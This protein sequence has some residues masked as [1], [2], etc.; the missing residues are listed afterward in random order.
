M[1]ITLQ[2]RPLLISG[3]YVDGIGNNRLY[4]NPL[5]YG[6]VTLVD[7]QTQDII[8]L[9][10]GKH[11]VSDIVQADARESDMVIEE[12]QTL[13]VCE[14][15][16][17]SEQF[18]HELREH[19]THQRSMAC[20]MHLTNRCNLACSYCY[21]HK[22]PGD[23]SLETGKSVID[24]MLE[25]CRKNDI[26]VLNIKFAGG[27][28]LLRFRMIQDLVD[29]AEHAKGTIQ[30][31]YVVLTNG[32]LVTPQKVEYFVNHSIGAG[33][34]L[35]G[36]GE[37]H[38]ANRSDN[39]GHGSF[40]G[41]VR[42]LQ[43]LKDA[44]IDPS[45]MVTVAP[46][47]MMHLEELTTFLMENEYYFRF[48]L[49]RDADT[50]APGLLSSIPQLIEAFHGVYDMIEADLPAKDITFIHKFG[51]TSFSRPVGRACG[52]GSNFFAAGHDGNLGV[53][54]LGLARPYGRLT[55]DGD[56]IE[57]MSTS[58][59]ALTNA[60]TSVYEH[61]K[62]CVWRTSCAGGCPLQTKA[63]LGRF[64]APTPYC[65]VY[66]QILPRVLR[67]KGLQMARNLNGVSERG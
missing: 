14:V 24:K 43:R 58:N 46:A 27:E 37:I 57:N 11:S 21:I 35:D 38:D 19:I 2:N 47:N 18:T 42:G 45:V 49:E 23:M 63:T 33:V 67:I 60:N 4:Y 55:D 5:G 15:L 8:D 59:V 13:A 10:D 28:P 62:E 50:G 25:S 48:S 40:T 65:E 39:K 51:D 9:C 66:K 52:A 34:S 16:R 44:G 53:C 12:V 1:E 6:G 29:Y 30:V 56:I 61:C 22:H 64:D 36:L 3:Q 20:W 26:G 7:Q 17:I 54:G 41:A 31:N 32:V